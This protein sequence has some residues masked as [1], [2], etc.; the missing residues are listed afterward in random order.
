MERR[1]RA[2]DATDYNTMGSIKD[3]LWK[4]DLLSKNTQTH[5]IFIRFYGKSG[6]AKLPVLHHRTICVS[7]LSVQ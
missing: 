5:N 1:G 2:R 7:L 4:P 3:A 6:E